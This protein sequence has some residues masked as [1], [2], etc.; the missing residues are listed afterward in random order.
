[1]CFTRYI[2]VLFCS[3]L[4]ALSLPAA[5]ATHLVTGN[6]YGF[7]VIS[8]QE[9]TATKFYAHPYSFSRPDPE[10]PL[11]EGIET[12]NFIKELGWSEGKGKGASAQYEDESHVI[13]VH[14][15]AGE[16]LYFM[17]FGFAHPALITSWKPAPARSG[18][19]HVEWSRPVKSRK[20]V[21]V[22]GTEVQIL[23]FDGIE[24]SLLIIPLGGKRSQTAPATDPRYAHGVGPCLFRERRQR[25]IDGERF[26]PVACRTFAGGVG[27]AGDHRAGAMA[28]QVR[29]AIQGR[30]RTAPVASKRSHAKDGTKPRTQSS[31]AA[32]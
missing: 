1:M 27:K 16:G 23:T 20:S 15:S 17:P 29:G 19:L 21:E 13:R 2:V 3:G 31:R 25:G 5:P 24:E 28:C 12:A 22:S 30:T 7:A 10:K 26:Q 14:T 6:G 4:F 9:G 11:S 8:P 32:Q 18:N